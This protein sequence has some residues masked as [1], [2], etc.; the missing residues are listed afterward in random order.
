MPFPPPSQQNQHLPQ[1]KS[2][3]CSPYMLLS[4]L[5]IYRTE[6]FCSK[7]NSMTALQLVWMSTSVILHC[8]CV[9]CKWLPG[10]LMAL[11]ELGSVT[12]WWVI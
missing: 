2:M 7:I 3:A 10:A 11:V 4:C 12:I 8:Y 1:L 5:W 9:K 6:A